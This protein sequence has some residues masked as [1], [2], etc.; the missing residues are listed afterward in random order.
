MLNKKLT[1]RNLSVVK[2]HN[3]QAIFE[4]IR[5][6]GPI[7]KSEIAKITGLTSAGIGKI[8]DQLV[9]DHLI[10]DTGF[11]ESTG[12]R[13]PSLYQVNNDEYYVIAINMSY[14]E[15]SMAAMSPEGEVIKKYDLSY[16]KGPSIT[17]IIDSIKGILSDEI[18]KNRK[19]L[20]IGVVAPGLIDTGSG[21]ILWAIA[22][23]WT[24]I[25]L[26]SLLKREFGLPVI[27]EK[28]TCAGLFAEKYYGQLKDVSDGLYIMLNSGSIGSAIMVD[29]KIYRGSRFMSGEI[30]HMVLDERGP[31]CHC[32][33]RGCLEAFLSNQSLYGMIDEISR[34]S[35]TEREFTTNCK[36]NK[37]LL[38]NILDESEK[39]NNAGIILMEK[40]TKYV[41]KALGSMITLVNP[42]C[43][44]IGGEV[45]PKNT[46]FIDKLKETLFRYG[47]K[48]SISNT[49]I[50]P[51]SFGTNQS[52]VGIT[53][54]LFKEVAL[55]ISED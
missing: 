28:D 2:S 3:T 4:V 5:V 37:S 41:A 39:G 53:A 11:A 18:L 51:C 44:I 40:A 20:G 21:T 52:L 14:F 13:R 49:S 35:R 27:I 12:G 54:L 55:N 31:L 43:V 23:D 29:D 45:G 47:L 33:Q 22:L 10:V 46:R 42:E 7:A 26:E 17:E 36:K 38:K 6:N 24:D 1:G 32:G 16:D 48:I 25:P 15:T 9:K 19:C 34:T 8:I 50:A 30:G